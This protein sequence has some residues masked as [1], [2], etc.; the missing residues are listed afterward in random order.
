MQADGKPRNSNGAYPP[1]SGGTE[2]SMTVDLAP[3][4]AHGDTGRGGGNRRG[5]CQSYF[6]SRATVLDRVDVGA[7]DLRNR[8]R[9]H[10]A[11][12]P[13]PGHDA[14]RCL[15]GWLI[16][17]VAEPIPALR[18]TILLGGI[19]LTVYFRSNPRGSSMHP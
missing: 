16:Y 5:Y 1:R 19:F 14:D 7:A 18:W 8:R 10:Q 9:E 17:L 3:T 6:V 13:A 4:T 11:F 2:P 12:W 15:T